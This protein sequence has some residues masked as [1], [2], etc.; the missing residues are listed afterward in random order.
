MKYLES[1]KLV[2]FFLFEQEELH[3]REI[4]GVFGPNGAG[5]SALLDAI[6]IAMMG[7]NT[8]HLAFNAQ[9][10]EKT[11]RSIRAYCLGQH[12]ADE[13]VRD[14]A[15]TYI[16]LL[17]RDSETNEPISMGLCIEASSDSDDHNV[18]GR[19]IAHGVEL[20]LGDHI[21]MVDGEERPRDWGAFRVQLKTRCARVSGDTDPIFHDAISYV[22]AAM[23]A[24][25]GSAGVP[26]NNLFTSAFRFALRMRFNKSVDHIIR[27]DVLGSN[28][29]NI[30]KFRQLTETF[31]KIN[32]IIEQV[33][34]KIAA[35]SA[36][37]DGFNLALKETRKAA[38]WN[39]LGMSAALAEAT[40]AERDAD[41]AYQRAEDRLGKARMANQKAVKDLADLEKD[42][43]QQQSRME[44][45]SAHKDLALAQS[46]K[47]SAQMRLKAKNDDIARHLNEIRALLTH[48]ANEPLLTAFKQQLLEVAEHIKA[49]SAGEITTEALETIVKAVAALSSRVGTAIFQGAPQI[50]KD[51][52]DVE[53]ELKHTE[54]SIGR[55]KEGKAPLS[56][57][58]GTLLSE[59]KDNGLLPVP[60]CDVVQI[61]DPEWQPA[62]EAYLGRNV[63]ALLVQE[64]EE[65]KAF[66]IYRELGG[67]RGI[68]GV[69]I[70]MA[71]RQST[72][73]TP[74]PGTVAELIVGNNSAAVTFLRR[75]FGDIMRASTNEEALAGKRTLT[76]D[77]M[78]VGQGAFER[79]QLVPLGLLKIGIAGG[80]SLPRLKKTLDDL[81]RKKKDLQA[82][83]DSASRL[84]T[85]FGSLANEQTRQ[86][87][88]GSVT[89][90]DEARADLAKANTR[91]ATATDAEYLAICD[92]VEK[93]KEAI[94]L[95]REAQ[96]TAYGET[97]KAESD[98]KAADEVLKTVRTKV[99]ACS[100]ACDGARVND[101]FDATF[102]AQH[103][104][105]LLDQYDEDYA[106]MRSYC[107]DQSKSSEQQADK[108]KNKATRDF[109]TFLND[110]RESPAQ[111]I[112]ENWRKASVW[113]TEQINRLIDT[114][115][116]L[117]K[118]EA[119]EAYQASQDAFRTDVAIELNDRFAYLSRTIDSLNSAL[120]SCPTFS[121]GERY[122]F[123][124]TLRP[125][126]KPL[127]KFI[128]DVATYGAVEDLFGG[129][130]DIPPEF[131]ALLKEKVAAG[132]AGQP[133]P[134][135]DYREFFE[136][137]VEILREDPIT[138]ERK[139]VGVLSK[140]IGAGSG[141]EHRAPLYV[142]AGAALASAYRL[143]PEHRDG[144]RLVLLDE[145]FDKMDLTNLI[146]TM[147]YL[148]DLGLQVIMASPGE[149]RGAL[150]AFMHRCYE[151]QR[152]TSSAKVIFEGHDIS[153]DMRATFREDLWEFH[154]ELITAELAA[155]AVAV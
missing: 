125:H 40:S 151:V 28:P 132:S 153:E 103:W 42:A 147:R 87:I 70:A 86:M 53:R 78:L 119:A 124:R 114:E 7:A 14:Y 4:T 59:L 10:D 120:T 57:P 123:I 72:G 51:L 85:T 148:E 83:Q 18:L 115:L 91:L 149:N 48:S 108:A 9:A 128:K 96:Q 99:E 36:V 81:R 56:G 65:A 92:R 63:E 73:E 131:E 84:V 29:T 46:D 76:K 47:Q 101:D 39:W 97:I 1:I 93:L 8:K 100:S 143:D 16:T 121:N 20:T 140:R 105:R 146:A 38:S 49:L 134:L 19:Y 21:E 116:A 102:A 155:T 88:I 144:I 68:H 82:R 117:H 113:L 133:S 62:I 110:F 2:Q 104:D 60:V 152:D 35:G 98:L 27:N 89:S 141:G 23:V 66:A 80:S 15:T 71:S 111:D 135:D 50:A 17:W 106:A 90:R 118:K 130:G 142:I 67:K 137:D 54:E 37:I 45:H 6:Q 11:T 25:R 55:A 94:S 107:S 109:F 43:E 138:K 74:K 126:L 32:A 12:T 31:K 64:H 139:S 79:L 52:S 129:A 13:R 22:K 77:G 136:F 33:E 61:S 122:Q 69:K 41:A 75:Q 95:A 58:A 5:K 3:F 24:L 150:D 154:P 30:A 127:M 44:S 112:Q 26:N 34:K 145:A